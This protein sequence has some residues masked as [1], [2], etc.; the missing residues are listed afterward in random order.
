MTTK[1]ARSEFRP[2]YRKSP[3]SKDDRAFLGFV[4]TLPCFICFHELYEFASRQPWV[5]IEMLN[6][7]LIP[8]DRQK[9]PTEAAHLGLSTSRRGLSQKYPAR[10][11]GP[12]CQDHHTG[13][14]TSHHAGT[15]TF[16]ERNNIDRDWIIE[17]VGK[18]YEA[19]K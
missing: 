10:E 16:W 7:E 18:L 13:L 5:L 8:D 1:I 11:S 6:D 9:T 12:L 15:K 19:S 14:K 4:K 3:L 17:L 2:K